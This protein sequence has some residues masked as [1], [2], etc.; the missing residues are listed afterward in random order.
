MNY[1]TFNRK[2]E[3]ALVACYICLLCFQG[4]DIETLGSETVVEN[5]TEQLERP[6]VEEVKQPDTPEAFALGILV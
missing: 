1:M 4:S 5:K 6:P 3:H 2:E